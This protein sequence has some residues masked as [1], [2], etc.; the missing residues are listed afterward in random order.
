MGKSFTFTTQAKANHWYWWQVPHRLV[1]RVPPVI[2]GSVYVTVW[3]RLKIHHSTSIVTFM[4]PTL[5]I[6]KHGHRAKGSCKMK[7]FVTCGLF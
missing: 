7:V 2:A 5:N 4:C 1:Y 6:K 3:G